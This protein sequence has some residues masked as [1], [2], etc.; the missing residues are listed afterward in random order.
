MQSV[1]SKQ[2]PGVILRFLKRFARRWLILTPFVL[3]CFAPGSQA[4]VKKNVLMINE[5][6]ESHPAP[7]LATNMLL[8]VLHS[9]RRFQVEFYLEKLDAVY[10]SPECQKKQRDFLAQ[11]YRDRKLDLIL[12]MGP[13]AIRFLAETS[14]SLFPDVPVVFCC[15]VP[16]Q[17]DKKSLPARFTGSWLQLEPARTLDAALRLLPETR[18]VFV[19][20]G[21]A[22]YDRH[23]TA[24]VNAALNPY[25]NELDVQYLTDLPMNQLQE[26]ARHFP[27]QS[28]V[29]YL[30]FFKDVDGQEFLTAADALGMI[31]AAS[32]APV[33]GMSDS[34]LGRGLVGGYVVS[35]EEQGKIAGRN[36]LAILGGKLPQEI[37]IVHAPGVYLFDWRELRRWN[38][39][40]SKL[41]DG[42]T[43]LFREPTLWEQHKQSLLTGLL[44]IVSL[45]SMTIYL[46][47]KQKQLKL[48]RETQEQLSG[49]LINAQETERSRLAAEIHDDFSQR[50]AALSLGLETAVE[51]IPE[52]LQKTCGQMNELIN[53]VSELGS[54]LHTLSH[55]LHSSTL[56]RLGLVAGVES[57]CKEFTAQQETQVAFS[58]HDVPRFV[59]PDVALC[60][61]RIVQEGLRNVKKHSGAANAL[62]RIEAMDDSLHLSITDDG[63]GF[64][65]TGVSSRHGLGLL[66]MRERVRLVAGRLEI[67]SEKK[68]GTRI[69]VWTPIDL[70]SDAK[71]IKPATGPAPAP[72]AA[73]TWSNAA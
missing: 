61:F 29:L 35:F 22:D 6:G 45:G 41:P 16:G 44:I 56:Q 18:H 72:G 46:L 58:H 59:P 62:V 42:S 39:D 57:F 7:Q 27:S 20:A 23:L 63:K 54:D 11:K 14:K 66:S 1:N 64:D 28:I 15:S 19:L 40:A 2:R 10:H 32:N 13:D 4:Q 71:R 68:K 17:I 30:S 50:L 51:G 73:S 5:P 48:A 65:V 67:S 69:D 55:R 3:V 38:L 36:A 9:D 60:L 25:E 31:A 49:M 53:T 43:I 33:F 34:Y 52:S 47:F 21:Q 8:S 26:R 24:L 12:L 37:P 70:N